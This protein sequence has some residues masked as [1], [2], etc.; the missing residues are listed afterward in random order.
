M[1][2]EIQEAI[3][4]HEILKKNLVCEN[5]SHIL[6]DFES[7]V[8]SLGKTYIAEFEVKISRSDFLRDKSK[9]RWKFKNEKAYFNYF[10]YVCPSGL[11]NVSEVGE[12]HG[13]IYFDGKLKVVK[14]A[15][16]IHKKVLNREKLISKFLR[17][18]L[19][20]KYF[21]KSLITIKNDNR[22]KN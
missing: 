14:K 2:K 16:L 10:Y 5:V 11:I 22:R 3:C 7:D 6:S 9:K 4:E 1:T 17:L 20:R 19:E 15:K 13:L 12:F 18:N 21:G 8:L